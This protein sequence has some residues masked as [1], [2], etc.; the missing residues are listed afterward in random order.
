[1]GAFFLQKG[2]VIQR[3]GVTLEYVS[4]HGND[5]Y[6]EDPNSGQRTTI[7]EPVFWGELSTQQLKIVDAF[8]SPKVLITP[9]EPAKTQL[10][11]LSSLPDKYQQDVER[12][13][14]YISRL[15][16]AGITRGQRRRIAE[17]SLKIAAQINDPKGAPGASTIQYW[18]QKLDS[19]QGEVYVLINGHSEKTRKLALDKESEEFLQ[20]QIDE[21]Y[22][23]N[24]RPTANG[25]YLAYCKELKDEN[26]QR[27]KD[28][29]PLLRRVSQRTFHL[30]INARP[31]K[32]LMIARLGREAARHHF[33]MIKGHLPCD[34]PLDYAEIDHTPMNLY[35]IDD[36]SYLPLGR[37]WLTAIKDRRSG[38]LLGFYVSFSPTGLISI[39]GAL[40]HSLVS[41]HLAYEQWPDIENPWA[42]FGRAHFYES[43]RGADFKSQRYRT[44]IISIGSMYEYCERRT[45]W[46]KGSIERFFLTLEQTLFESI[47]GRTFS[48]R[49]IALIRH[50]PG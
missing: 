26:L 5:I 45:P 12:K 48:S 22:A 15:K 3:E 39:F 24:T 47:P 20:R 18:W 10:R 14:N 29:L 36:E 35:V 38:M 34:Y 27:A 11:A 4:R 23:L 37:P 19:N 28:G 1:M 17:E 42:S 9:Q 16:N 41:H 25:A 44:A 30:R 49:A 43:D 21:K 13:T 32:E 40:K 2:L 46:L 6:F 33:K 8:S 50:A 31:K 7:T